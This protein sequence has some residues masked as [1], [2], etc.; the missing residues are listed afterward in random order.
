MKLSANEEYGLRCLVRIGYAGDG[1]SLTKRTT[2]SIGYEHTDTHANG[3]P[4]EGEQ[5]IKGNLFTGFW[6]GY[7]ERHRIPLYFSFRKKKRESR[8]PGD[9]ENWPLFRFVY[10]AQSDLCAHFSWRKWGALLATKPSRSSKTTPSF[11][12]GQNAPRTDYRSA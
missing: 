7:R 9:R 5:T 3:C 1:G 2:D 11:G 4:R 12:H 10:H 6:N 8:D